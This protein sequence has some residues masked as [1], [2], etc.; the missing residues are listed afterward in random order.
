VGE[1]HITTAGDVVYLL[2]EV[3]SADGHGVVH[4]I[5]S[6][7]R[8]LRAEGDRLTLAIE[9]GSRQEV[10]TCRRAF[11]IPAERSLAARRRVLRS[12]PRRR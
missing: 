9:S 8:V 4:A 5:G 6:Q 1:E 11:V 2:A 12:G 3:R 7:A 10:V